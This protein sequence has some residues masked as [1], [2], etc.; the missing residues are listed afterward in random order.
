M[1]QQYWQQRF[2]TLPSAPPLVT[3][4]TALDNLVHRSIMPS[5]IPLHK[6]SFFQRGILCSLELSLVLY[7]VRHHLLEHQRP[8]QSGFTPKRS[9]SDRVLALSVL[10]ERR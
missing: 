4:V 9:M 6:K 8:E 10:T 1:T 5:M 2:C 3:R 7:R